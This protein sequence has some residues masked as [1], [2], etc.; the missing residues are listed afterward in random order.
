M[1][2]SDSLGWKFEHPDILYAWEGACVWIPCRYTILRGGSILENLTMYHNPKYDNVTKT[3]NGTILYQK[4]KTGTLSSQPKRVQ[5][6]GNMKDN[7]T[8]RIDSVSVH[9][10]GQLGLRMVSKNDKWMEFIGLNVSRKALGDRALHVGHRQGGRWETLNP[11]DRTPGRGCRLVTRA[12]QESRSEHRSFL[13]HPTCPSA[14]AH[15]G[16]WVPGCLSFQKKIEIWIF[17]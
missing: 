12:A 15:S 8:L 2:F 1:A 16:I 13:Q 9:D 14:S 4:T 6:L 10:S 7:C 3:Y 5:F 17:K 11:Q